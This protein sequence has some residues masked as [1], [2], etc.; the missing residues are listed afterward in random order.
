MRNC[1][2]LMGFD[3][4]ICKCVVIERD[5]SI[6]NCLMTFQFKNLSQEEETDL[7]NS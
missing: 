1:L 4:A 5:V 2:F 7:T 3:L 6:N